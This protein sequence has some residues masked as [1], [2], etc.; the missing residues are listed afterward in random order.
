MLKIGLIVDEI[1]TG[2]RD[3]EKI[4]AE[5][6]RK[7]T[8]GA[9]QKVISKRYAV[10]RIASGSRLFDRL[11]ESD[12]D[13]V[14]NLSTGLRGESRQS[15]IPAMLEML[16]IPYVGSG[17]LGHAVA[18]NKAA[19]KKLFKF[20]DVPTPYFQEFYTGEERTDPNLKFPV[21]VKP[22]C[23]GSGFGIHKDSL[24][25]CE[26]AL[27]EVVLNRLETYQPPALAEEYIEGREFTV[28]IIGNGENKVILPIVEINFE[29]VTGEYDKFNTFESKH[30]QGGQKQSYC[31]VI[32]NAETKRS[33][34]RSALMAF[35][36]LGCKD[37][38]RVDIRMRDGISYVIE[39]NS[40]PGLMPEYSDFPI[41]AEAAGMSYEDLIMAILKEG[42]NR[43]GA[44]HSTYQHIEHSAD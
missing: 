40:L 4:K 21:I 38:A 26:E 12:V 9:I 37:F 1:E 22:A 31:P 13:I 16:G 28:G 17:V 35:E 32:L 39:V 11:R 18:L 5:E 25:F 41:M 33:V 8:A 15:Q 6:Q 29:N 2:V 27:H 30:G 23:E 44:W 7:A 19:A 14:F 20:H 36:A 43:T 24:V 34:E 3:I 10:T 42:I